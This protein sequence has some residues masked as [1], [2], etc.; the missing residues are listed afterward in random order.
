[1]LQKKLWK[2]SFFSNVSVCWT[3]AQLE[4]TLKALDDFK[5]KQKSVSEV[6]FF[7]M[8]KYI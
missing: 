2:N 6:M 8:Q 1:M 3:A 5:N 7:D 4:D